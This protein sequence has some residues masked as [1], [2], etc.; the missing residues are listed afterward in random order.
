VLFLLF[1]VVSRSCADSVLSIEQN[2]DLVSQLEK[3]N[4]GLLDLQARYEAKES[5]FLSQRD[6]LSRQSEVRFTSACA[7]VHHI[8]TVSHSTAVPFN[9]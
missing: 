1:F 3:A 5:K 8:S 4:K 9:T 2:S 6:L 7:R